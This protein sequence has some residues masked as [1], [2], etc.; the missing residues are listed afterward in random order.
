MRQTILLAD[1]SPTIQRLV[2]QTFADTR[3]DIVTVNN[4]DAATRKFD[5][6]EPDIVLAD[7]Y[8]PGKN[9]YEV[10]AHVR[11]HSTLSDTPV[12]LLVGAFDAFDE[13]IAARAGA[14]AHITKPFEPRALVE[15]VTSKAPNTARAKKSSPE[16]QPAKAEETAVPAS[17]PPVEPVVVPVAPQPQE[18]Q[19][20]PEVPEV[21]AVPEPE[22][23][24]VQEPVVSVPIE[25][26]VETEIRPAVTPASE[27]SPVADSSDL[28]GLANLF[29]PDVQ[30][31][32][33]AGLSDEEIDK[34]VD[35]VV[36][37]ISAQVVESVAW[38][39]VPDIATKI[40]RDE[41]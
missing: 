20:T 6:I 24:K 9:G 13:A 25:K 28:L 2:S 34:I 33:A 16:D 8:M 19:K 41:L 40:L 12:I 17:I 18:P 38:D 30:R 22:V 4:G 15:L 39:V 3:F 11:A 32:V 10:C 37:K 27:P 1:D 26:L 31:D 36:R 14:A 7:I 23:Q 5:E 29:P 21:S 35:R